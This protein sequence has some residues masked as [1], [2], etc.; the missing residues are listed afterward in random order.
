MDLSAIY[1]E[2]KRFLPPSIRLEV[3]LRRLR[4]I[5]DS[6]IAYHF[7]QRESC[8]RIMIDVGAAHGSAL[9]V[10]AGDRWQIFAFEPNP[11]NRKIL[12]HAV[13]KYGNVKVDG[14]AVSDHAESGVKFYASSLSDG[15]GSLSP[16]DASHDASYEVDITSLAD[17]FREPQAVGFLKIDTEGFD[18]HVL[19]GVPLDRMSPHL[20]LCEFDNK[21]SVPLGYTMND[22]AEY[23]VEHGYRVLISESDAIPDYGQLPEWRR[24]AIYPTP[25]LDPNATGNLFAA[26][27]DGT[28][29]RLCKITRRFERRFLGR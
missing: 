23:L 5:N 28:F 13:R 17:V 4:A 9:K 2:Y 20:I 18:F 3:S 6:V 7:L 27:D 15:L 1:N 22:M 10:F 21:K 25:L 12:E 26:K 11:A 29:D 14:R 8:P 19:R 16:F 24:F